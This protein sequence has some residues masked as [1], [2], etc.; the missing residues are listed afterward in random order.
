MISSIFIE[1]PKLAFV[2]SIV[3]VLAGAICIFRLPVAEYP[4]IAPPT[5][6]V[7]ASYPGASAEV[8]A[9]TVASVIEEQVNGIE[10]M[11]VPE[12]AVQIVD[13]QRHAELRLDAA[14]RLFDANPG[15]FRL[16][17][18]KKFHNR[19]HSAFYYNNTALL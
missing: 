3:T 10:N 7:S 14:Q 6:Q 12:P 13:G 16:F 17:A 2:I 5:V 1:R 9:N 4:E 18:R 8:I 15:Q 19:L 11:R